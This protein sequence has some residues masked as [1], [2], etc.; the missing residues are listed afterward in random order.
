MRQ[1]GL[2]V[3]YNGAA[4]LDINKPDDPEKENYDVAVSDGPVTSLLE[5]PF[6]RLPKGTLVYGHLWTGGENVVGHYN[7]VRTPDGH[8]YPVC[9]TTG[10]IP[11]ATESRPGHALVRPNSWVTV[12]DRFP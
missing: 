1:L 2:E 10:D 12:V 7:R 6:G 9:F 11:K 4:Q 8:E 3:G 5:E